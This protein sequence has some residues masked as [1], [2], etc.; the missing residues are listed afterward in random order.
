MASPMVEIADVRK[1]FGEHEVLKGVSVDIAPG[2]VVCVIGPSGSGKTTL[3]RM[4]AGLEQ[5]TAGRVLV[6]GVDVTQL[7]PRERNVAFVF[8]SG[9]LYGH[10]TVEQNLAFAL[11]QQTGTGW[12]GGWWSKSSRLSSEQIAERVRE[13]AERVGITSWLRRRPAELSGGEQQ[14]VA[15]ARAMIRRPRLVLLDEP[16]ANLDA[17]VRLALAN[18]LKTQL[19]EQR[20]TAIY[21]THDLAEALRLADRVAVIVGGRLKQIGPPA[22]VFDQPEGAE[23]A[24]LFAPLRRTEQP[25]WWWS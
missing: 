23:V 13:T 4:I 5:P 9:S 15:L 17:P 20:L 3:L 25:G 21:V 1:R 12:F 24:E 11:R 8:Q 18:D 6:D 19:R 7:P 16:L 2:E 10:M 14:R 22:E